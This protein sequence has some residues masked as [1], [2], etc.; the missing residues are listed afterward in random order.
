MG[1][2]RIVA[3]RRCGKRWDRLLPEDIAATWGS[4]AEDPNQWVLMW[5]SPSQ[6]LHSKN[7]GYTVEI[8]GGVRSIGVRAKE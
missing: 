5:V 3:G 7:I 4:A 2:V 6:E 8:G 1:I